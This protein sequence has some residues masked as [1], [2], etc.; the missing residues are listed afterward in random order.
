MQQLKAR[1][2]QLLKHRAAMQQ[3]T[4]QGLQSAGQRLQQL[5]QQQQDM[6]AISAGQNS[7]VQVQVQPQSH[8]AKAAANGSKR[9]VMIISVVHQKEQSSCVACHEHYSLRIIYSFC[10]PSHLIILV[11]LPRFR[12]DGRC[13]PNFPAPGAPA[14]GECDPT[15]DADQRGPCCNPES[16]YCGNL[17]Q[18]HW[19][20]CDCVGCVDYSQPNAGA[21]QNNNPALLVRRR[22]KGEKFFV[23][24]ERAQILNQLHVCVCGPCLSFPGFSDVKMRQ[25]L[26]LQHSR[27]I[28]CGPFS[29][30]YGWLQPHC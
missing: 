5:E 26:L 2:E 22:G 21:G 6:A 14:F 4:A 15:A 12:E 11:Q 17:R 23:K 28:L 10:P 7:Q 1:A 9:K 25:G 24:G 16:G 30:I 13:G 18:V 27:E 29:A 3:Q 19:G 8:K 20:H